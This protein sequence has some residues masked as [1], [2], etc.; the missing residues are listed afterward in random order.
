MA[1]APNRN[2]PT[3]ITTVIWD[4]RKDTFTLYRGEEVVEVVEH[5]TDEGKNPRWTDVSWET[6]MY[7]RDAR[8]KQGI[9]YTRME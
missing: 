1:N 8:G 2:I 7:W 3:D 5:Y 9:V 4:W 6:L